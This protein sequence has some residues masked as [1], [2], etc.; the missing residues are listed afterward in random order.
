MGLGAEPATAGQSAK[1]DPAVTTIV[2]CLVQGNPPGDPKPDPTRP[3]TNDYFVR[4]PTVSLPVGATVMVGKAGTPSTA[5]SAGTPVR[6]SYYR[7]TG[8]SVDQLRPHL[9]HRVEV[10]GH[11]L[12]TKPDATGGVTTTRTT[13]DA[14][15]KPTVTVETRVDVA[16]D[17]H[18]T[19]LKMVSA[20]CK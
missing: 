18:A 5:S 20:S 8:L 16:G 4:T 2:G 17:L 7:V 12:P 15:G 14:G 19:A 13:V 10:Q 6:D 11:L 3:N 1:P 9:D